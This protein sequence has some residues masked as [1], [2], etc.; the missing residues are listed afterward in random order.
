MMYII[1]LLLSHTVTD[2]IFQTEKMIDYK[3]A[4]DRKGYIYHEL[5]LLI[6][7]IPVIILSDLCNSSFLIPGI[8]II[9][10]THPLIDYC[11]ERL[12]HKRNIKIE[13]KKKEDNYIKEEDNTAAYFLALFFADQLLHIII[14]FIVGHI[15]SVEFNGINQF[16]IENLLLGNA[17]NYNQLKKLLIILYSSFSGMYLVPLFLDV[18]YKKIDNYSDAIDSLLAEDVGDKSIPFIKDVKTGKWIGVLERLLVS[19][20]LILSQ[21]QLIGF[22]LAAKSLARF[23]QMDK[24]VFSEY[25]LIGTLI[26]FIYAFGIYGIF[27]S[28]L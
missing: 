12:K 3:K 28:L 23:K 7:L 16:L 27:N 10:V 26:S 24:K 22:I 15:T 5:V 1:I 19:T 17:I 14:I 25:F 2:F 4:F 8:L 6:T 20:A 9:L 13:K 11:K 18:L 21:I